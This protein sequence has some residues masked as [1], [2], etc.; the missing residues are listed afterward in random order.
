M[1]QPVLSA[2]CHSHSFSV[3]LPAV[4]VTDSSDFRSL[5]RTGAKNYEANCIFS[6]WDVWLEN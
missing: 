6:T 2:K 1:K 5:V 3:A 4:D